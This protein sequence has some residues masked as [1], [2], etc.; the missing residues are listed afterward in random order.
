MKAKLLRTSG[1]VG[2][3]TF[4]DEA[5]IPQAYIVNVQ[6]LPVVRVGEEFE[7]VE[8]VLEKATPYGIDMAIVY[9]DGL[10]IDVY[11]FQKR[12]YAE[13]VVS[14]EDLKR[15]PTAIKR[16]LFSMLNAISASV[17]KAIKITMEDV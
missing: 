1:N 14:L 5:D 4:V 16:V 7:L 13:G 15:D 10:F 2:L 8:T 9:P 3:I 11:D 17:Y 6:L 12:L